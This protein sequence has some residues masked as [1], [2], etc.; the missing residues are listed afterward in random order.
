MSVSMKQMLVL[1]RLDETRRDPSLIVEQD[2][3]CETLVYPMFD[4]IESPFDRA[5]RLAFIGLSRPI[6]NPVCFNAKQS[7]TNCS[8]R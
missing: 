3:D 6:F 4:R 7:G 5:A 2:L 1:R 8:G